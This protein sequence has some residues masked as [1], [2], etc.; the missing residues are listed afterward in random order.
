[1]EYAPAEASF[2]GNLGYTLTL[3]GRTRE[4]RECFIKLLDAVPNQ[5]DAILGLGR[6]A[7]L[8]G[9]VGQAEVRLRQ[10]LEI[11]PAMPGP[12][13]SI[14]HLRRMTSLD[15]DWLQTALR[16]VEVT[17][18]K[19]DLAE[20]H[21]AIGKYWDDVGNYA[22][23]FEAFATANRVQKSTTQ[24]YNRN[25][26]VQYVDDLMRAYT[27][28]VVISLSKQG[29]SS[30]KPIFVV[31]MPRSGTSLVEQIIASHPKA[32]G[33]GELGF[34]TEFLIKH[35]GELRRAAVSTETRRSLADE[36]LQLLA[37]YSAEAS[38]IV[39]KAPINSEM[40]GPIHT[41]LPEARIL[42]LYRNP[43]DTC[44]SCFFQYLSPALSYAMDLSDLNHYY[45]EH[46][47]LIK[48]WAGV[49]P[50]SALMVVPYEELVTDQESWTR[51]ILEFVGLEWDSNCLKFHQTQ[52]VVVTASTLQVRQKIYRSSVGRWKNYEEFIGPLKGLDDL[53]L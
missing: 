7:Q 50:K 37:G 42:Y 25:S 45:R 48:H 34:W 52:R 13:A 11:D 10:A 27:R 41:I 24:G 22:K 47:R 35:Q 9:D 18:K 16:L 44:L 17:V 12:L 14:A 2:Q 1:V 36:Y 33:A 31:G 32:V 23:A 21:F 49:L 20:L 5:I 28:D 29:S 51:R 39:D 43:I 40:L 46:H 26:R 53:M 19:S 4:A 38:R 8:E 15:A 3:L 30:P 6:L